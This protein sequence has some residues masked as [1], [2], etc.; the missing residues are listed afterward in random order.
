M[1]FLEVLKVFRNYYGKNKQYYSEIHPILYYNDEFYTNPFLNNKEEIK[2]DHNT[3]ERLDN[4][5][6]NYT[7]GYN[8]NNFFQLFLRILRDKNFKMN[9]N[10]IIH[11]MIHDFDT[12]NLY[13]E[14]NLKQYKI[15]RIDVRNIIREEKFNS[16]EFIQ[17]CSDYFSFILVLIDNDEITSF[18]PRNNPNILAP[19]IY[20]FY[21]FID[22]RFYQVKIDNISIIESK[23][24]KYYMKEDKPKLERHNCEIQEEKLPEY[25]CTKLIKMKLIELQEIAKKLNIDI[26]KLNPKK[27]RMINKKKN[28]LISDIIGKN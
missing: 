23:S 13:K 18:I 15:K 12:L 27:T 25:D 17:F 19:K 7:I 3:F 21:N 9:T 6:K 10:E 4:L 16:K 5:Y 26:K 2:E 14:Y 11:Q 28:E 8:R 20:I 22:Q 24:D 1:D